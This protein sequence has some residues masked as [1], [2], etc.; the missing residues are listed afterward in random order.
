MAFLPIKAGA[1][2]HPMLNPV[3]YGDTIACQDRRYLCI[4]DSMGLW[5]VIG[6]APQHRVCFTT[7]SQNDLCAWLTQQDQQS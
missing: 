5:M 6:P 3:S 4:T 1:S 2:V 7:N